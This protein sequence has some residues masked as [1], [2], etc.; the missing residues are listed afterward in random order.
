[1]ETIVQPFIKRA[2]V[3]KDQ[4]IKK[5]VLACVRNDFINVLRKAGLGTNS[6]IVLRKVEILTLS[7]EAGIPTC[8]MYIPSYS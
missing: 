8:V 5:L 4:Y 3:V 7:G 1:M 2:H 6:R